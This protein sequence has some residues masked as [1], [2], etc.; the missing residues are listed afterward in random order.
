MITTRCLVAGVLFII[1]LA[2][3]SPPLHS[4]IYSLFRSTRTPLVAERR[5]Y[6]ALCI[7]KSYYHYPCHIW[8]M[9]PDNAN[10]PYAER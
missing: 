3:P 1:L 10:V 8:K 6:Y 9:L 7:H 2:M 4:L 5:R